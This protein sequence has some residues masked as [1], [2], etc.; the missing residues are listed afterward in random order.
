MSFSRI[1]KRM[2]GAIITASMVFSLIPGM[3][4]FADTTYRINNTVADVISLSITKDGADV[5]SASSGST[6]TVS[7]NGTSYAGGTGWT[8][9]DRN[10]QRE[11]LVDGLAVRKADGTSAAT[12]TPV[13]GRSGTWTFTMPDSDVYITFPELNTSETV[14]VPN[15]T[16]VF[17]SGLGDGSSYTFCTTHT[18]NGDPYGYLAYSDGS[19]YHKICNDDS[20]S[21][22]LDF[23]I[24]GSG[25]VT[26]S[27]GSFF[28]LGYGLFSS[29]ATGNFTAQGTSGNVTIQFNVVT[30]QPQ[31]ISAND[32]SV[33]LGTTGSS[34]VASVTTGD[35]TLTYSVTSGS[36]VIQVNTDTGAIT[37]LATGT[38]TVQIVAS[39]TATYRRTTRNIRVTVTE[40]APGTIAATVA[41]FTGEYDGSAHGATIT[42]TDPSAGATVMFGTSD[43]TYDLTESPTYTAVG[44]Y[45]VYYKITATGYTDMTGSVTITITEPAPAPQPDPE[46]APA[47]APAG[48]TPEQIRAQLISNFVE[49][50]Y[51]V[52]LDR[53]YDVVGRDYWVDQLMNQGNSGSYVAK[54]FFHSQ[55]FLARDLSDEEFVTVLYSVFFDRTP[56]AEGFANWTNALANGATRDQVIAGF[57]GSPEWAATCA[58]YEVNI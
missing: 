42:V 10:V 8:S 24:P 16:S 11:I 6:I 51:I 19:S 2:M 45:T 41:G 48:P 40:P 52:A 25:S 54:G 58:R 57:A 22:N 34:V 28:H 49:R 3:M 39:E 56:D 38:A 27:D 33:P 18:G 17:R 9:N 31:T 47:P 37:T 13:S 5:T 32:V 20:G 14:T 50:L 12:L 29:S 1:G 15:N 21:S 7:V 30:K 35:G 44:T 46:P 43:G 23:R 55:E 4:L 36:D 26:I 53:T